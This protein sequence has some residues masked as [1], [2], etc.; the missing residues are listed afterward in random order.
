VARV[1]V[2]LVTTA[3]LG[4]EESKLLDRILGAAGIPEADV[5]AAVLPIRGVPRLAVLLGEEATLEAAGMTLD[6][7]RRGPI[8]EVAI[9]TF[10]TYH[11]G[12]LLLVP[13]LKAEAWE[14]WR[15]VGEAY[16]RACEIER[17]ERLYPLVGSKVSTPKGAGV[18]L[19]VFPGKAVVV[20]DSR[21]D[22]AEEFSVAEIKGT[23]SVSG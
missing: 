20:L 16:R 10:A 14:D 3:P 11:P 4:A 23:V 1:K 6:E 17:A 5:E 12:E 13:S 18:L 2:M 19:Q 15:R 9:E 7:A 21:R 22:R 8:H